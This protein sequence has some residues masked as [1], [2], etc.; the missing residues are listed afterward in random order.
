M[1]IEKMKDIDTPIRT[2]RDGEIDREID[3]DGKRR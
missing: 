3:I 2:S 1:A